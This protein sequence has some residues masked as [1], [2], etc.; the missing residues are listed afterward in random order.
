MPVTTSCPNAGILRRLLLGDLSPSDL[1]ML[2][3]HVLGC[4]R[5]VSPR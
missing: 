3:E 2:D 1:A 4:D 5:C